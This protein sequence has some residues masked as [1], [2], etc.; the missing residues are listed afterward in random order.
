MM[1]DIVITAGC[2]TPTAPSA[3]QFK[4]LTALDLSTPS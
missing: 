2:R 1:N 3:G 4:T